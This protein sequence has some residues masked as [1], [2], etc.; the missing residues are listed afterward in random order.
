MRSE[1]ADPKLPFGSRYCRCNACGKYFTAVTPF[2]L[3]RVGAYEARRCLTT[4]EM[5]GIG[6]RENGRGYWITRPRIE[7]LE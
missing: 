2:D 1:P 7:V 3:H 6:M 5:L 4:A